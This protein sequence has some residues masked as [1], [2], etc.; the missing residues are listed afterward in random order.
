MAV[1]KS[2]GPSLGGVMAVLP[3]PTTPWYKQ[4]HLAKLNGLIL[5]LVCF[6]SAIG[7]DGSLLNSL[8]SFPQWNTFM[9]NPTGEW[10]GFIN[11]TYFIGFIV[12]CP[13]SSWLANKYGRRMP[14]F[15]SFIPLALGVGLQTSAQSRAQWIAG[16]FILGLP[17]GM[18]ATAVPL[19]ITE[20]AYPSQRSVVSALMNC[21]YFVGGII[22]SWASYG[23]RNY[24]D[25]A[26]RIPTLLQIALPLVGLPALIMVE[27][28]P[29]WLVSVGREEEARRILAKLHAGGDVDQPLVNFELHEITT[30]I[31]SEKQATKSTSYMTLVSTKAH[32]RRF[33]ITLT[34][35][36]YCQWVGNGVVSYYLSTVLSTVGI[37]SVTDQTLINGCLQI[38]SLIAACTGAMCVER[39]GRRPLLLLSCAIMLVSFILI[40]ALSGSFANTGSKPVGITMIP[41][42]FLFNAGYGVAITPL[43]VA[44]P[45]EL[46]PFQLRSRGM[47]A[48]WMIM[49]SALIFNV[50]VNPIALAAIGWKYYI[51]Y[52]VLLVSYG[53]VI[54]FFYPE[55]KGRTL[56]EISVV[57]GDAPE[58]LYESE[59]STKVTEKADVKH[60]D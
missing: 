21:N 47:S 26:W 46:W 58:G 6:Q 59:D 8:Q 36:I 17:T 24:D 50:F 51:V 12:A 28:S 14:I 31:E 10:S 41:F 2:S 11:C 43:Q 13:P 35:A 25:W 30:A 32:R 23:T 49:I 27:E 53:L 45:L 33:F 9:G 5:G 40:T 39:L 52:V 18:F 4:S 60:L 38:W 3:N 29:R 42:I 44:Y 20:I 22:A 7:Y 55:T 37:T 34:L 56:E 15:L 48:L 1:D 19:L 16:R 54:F 57:F